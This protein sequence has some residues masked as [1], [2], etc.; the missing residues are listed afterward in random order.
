MDLKHRRSQHALEGFEDE[1]PHVQ[2]RRQLLA[3]PRLQPARQEA[4]QSYNPTEL[5]SPSN[6][7]KLESG[8]LTEPLDRKEPRPVNTLI[9]DLRDPEDKTPGWQRK[10]PSPS[11]KPDVLNEKGE[12][13]GGS[14]LNSLRSNH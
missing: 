13:Q 9:S 6:L 7:N 14:T 4:P 11:M 3:A 12:G 5:D 2:V 10:I 8:F 1:G